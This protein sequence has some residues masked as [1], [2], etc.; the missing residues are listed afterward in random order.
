M[1]IDGS[2]RLIRLHRLGDTQR[3][4]LVLD[5]R[6]IE[7]VAEAGPQ[8]FSL[9]IGGRAYAIETG[10]GR[11]GRPPE[12]G[13]R[14]IDG[15]WILRAPLTGVVTELRVVVGDAVEPGSVLV[16]IEAMKM[17]NELRSPV[18]GLVS[19]LLVAETEL[20]EIGAALL[21]VAAP[22]DSDA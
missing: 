19:A 1:N 9:Q 17:L 7:V 8:G 5:D 22:A 14:F 16:I 11:P 2:W 12:E 13:D 10:R 6:V 15:E 20:A 3:Y 21:R 4:V 18:R